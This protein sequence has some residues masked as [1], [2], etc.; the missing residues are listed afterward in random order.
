MQLLAYATDLLRVATA[1]LSPIYD[2]VCRK[3]FQFNTE[4][5]LIGPNATYAFMKASSRTRPYTRLGQQ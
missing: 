5:C 3:T 1:V 4:K 2:D